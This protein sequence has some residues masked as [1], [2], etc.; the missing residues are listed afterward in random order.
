MNAAI[1][2]PTPNRLTLPPEQ[3]AEEAEYQDQTRIRHNRWDEP[4]QH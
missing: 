1:L 3:D 4:T 2:T